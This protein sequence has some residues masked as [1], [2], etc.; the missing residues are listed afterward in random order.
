[1]KARRKSTEGNLIKI[2]EMMPEVRA[3]AKNPTPHIARARQMAFYGPGATNAFIEARVRFGFQAVE[4]I[5]KAL[6]Y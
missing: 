5:S 2:R 3:V 1:M 6:G 4:V